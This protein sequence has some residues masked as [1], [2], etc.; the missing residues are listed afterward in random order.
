VKV[1]DTITRMRILAKSIKKE[2]KTIGF[3]PTMGYLHE[4]HLSLARAA[5][6]DADVAVMS[7][8]V[9]P[10]QFGP[11][12]DF[13]KYP[14]DLKR[15]KNL[16]ASAGIDIIFIPAVNDMYPAGYS[17]YI[18]VEGLAGTLCGSVRPGHF[19]GVTTVVAK[20]FGIVSPD[21]A[22]FGQKD[23]QQAIIVKKMADD[24]STGI[25]IKMMPIIR[26]PDG[27][28]MSSRNIYLSARE[29]DDASILHKALKKAEE[30]ISAGERAPGKVTTQMRRIIE[31]A[32]S[33]KI[34]YISTVDASLLNEVKTIR[35][36][37]LI[38]AAVFIGKTRLIDN[39]II[40]GIK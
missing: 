38:A 16:A 18:N 28:A 15:D 19:R 25:E 13:A 22:Y 2:G 40:K 8:F 33:A 29:R 5:K 24:L 11:K 14:R 30:M 3:V 26:E 4:G 12:E 17:T 37:I 1:V 34:E 32:A 21:I 27:L 7:I 10:V 23:A 20:L 39:I 35:G 31:K 9:N 6:K 36:D